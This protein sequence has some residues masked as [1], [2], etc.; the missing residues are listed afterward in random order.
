MPKDLS[1]V[2]MKTKIYNSTHFL[3]FRYRGMRSLDLDHII[4]KY[5]LT[6]TKRVNVLTSCLFLRCYSHA[7][8]FLMEKKNIDGKFN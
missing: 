3:A 4:W 2:H 5:T 6:S 1:F 8:L 7:L